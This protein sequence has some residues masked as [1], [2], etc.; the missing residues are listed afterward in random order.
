MIEKRGHGG[1]VSTPHLLYI[2]LWNSL[3]HLYNFGDCSIWLQLN[4]RHGTSAVQFIWATS[5]LWLIQQ[6]KFYWISH[7][8]MVA[9]LNCTVTEGMNV[10][11]YLHGQKTFSRTQTIIIPLACDVI[12]GRYNRLSWA[13]RLIYWFGWSWWRITAS[14]DWQSARSAK[15][16][17]QPISSAQ[18]IV[19][20]LWSRDQLSKPLFLLFIA[21]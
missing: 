4:R 8:S 13:D 14:N 16:V 10:I 1:L 9:Q 17:D 19:P 3:Y 21:A 11:L 20:I 5:D 18:P 15:S 2:C 12:T 6:N 7:R